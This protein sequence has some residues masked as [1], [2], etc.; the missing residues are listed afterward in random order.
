MRP[1]TE[2]ELIA[3]ELDVERIRPEL[4][5]AQL[6]GYW[7]WLPRPATD[8]T[9]QLGLTGYVSTLGSGLLSGYGAELCPPGRDL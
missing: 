9:V 5:A 8:G 1:L 2:D 4:K 3:L 6:A 7:S